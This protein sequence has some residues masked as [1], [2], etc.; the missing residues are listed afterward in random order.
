MSSNTLIGEWASGIWSSL[1][2][3]PNLSSLTLSGYAVQP[4]T[5][6]TLNARLGTCYSGVGTGA[7]Y[8]ASPDLT[9][10][11]LAIVEGLFLVSWYNQLAFSNM[12]YG[13]T[14]VPW[15]RLREGDET[16]ER[17]NPV[18]IGKEYGEMSK[19]AS[20]TLNYLVNAYVDNDRGTSATVD[21]LNPAYPYIASAWSVNQRS[22]LGPGA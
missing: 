3:P 11:E 14:S 16:I 9:N 4:N 17:G 15:T 7:A 5:L 2:S 12:G 20:L 19:Q 8:D 18:N 6:G 13:G 21:Y 1:G 10:K 22:I